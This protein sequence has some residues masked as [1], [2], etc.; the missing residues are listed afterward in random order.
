MHLLNAVLVAHGLGHLLSELGQ[1]LAEI[2][3]YLLFCTQI[4]DEI[5]YALLHGLSHH[6]LLH[7]NSVYVGLMKKQFLK[8]KLF[9][10]NAVGVAV[11]GRFLIEHLLIGFL[12]LAF[13][14]G[15]VADHPCHF[16]D[17]VV[18]GGYGGHGY[19]GKSRG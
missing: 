17:N 9:G 1:R 4:C 12:D 14:D 2:F 13:V 8:G 19:C 18:V 7:L 5:V 15:L 6:R 10:N 16:I 3:L 11:D